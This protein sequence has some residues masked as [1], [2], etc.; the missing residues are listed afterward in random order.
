MARD[1]VLPTRNCF[2]AFMKCDIQGLSDDFFMAVQDR[3]CTKLAYME[4]YDKPID[5]PLKKVAIKYSLDRDILLISPL[6]TD[7]SSKS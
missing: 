6:E 2:C 3:D 7:S 5:D 1:K 4:N